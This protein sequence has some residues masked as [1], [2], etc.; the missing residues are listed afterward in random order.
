LYR[1]TATRRDLLFL[2]ALFRL[3]LMA[4]LFLR[5]SMALRVRQA[6]LKKAGQYPSS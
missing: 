2:L 3:A 5:A 1:C 6:R 4:R